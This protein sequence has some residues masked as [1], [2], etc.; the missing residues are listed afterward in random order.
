[1]IKFMYPD[2]PPVTRVGS[3]FDWT[4]FSSRMKQLGKE[5]EQVLEHFKQQAPPEMGA[6]VQDLER[7]RKM[8]P[9]EI[10]ELIQWKYERQ[11]RY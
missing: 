10:I 9:C 1:L 7:R 6:K 4:E 11:P 2:L 5:P 8:Q 3:Y